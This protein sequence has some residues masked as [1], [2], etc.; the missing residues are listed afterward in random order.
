MKTCKVMMAWP[1][2]PV[3]CLSRCSL[4]VGPS[5]PSSGKPNRGCTSLRQLRKFNLSQELMVQFYTATIESVITMSITVW[6]S[7]ATKHDTHGV[8]HIIKSAVK[9][10]GVKLPTLLDQRKPSLIHHSLAIT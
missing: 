1:I 6:G 3:P 9:T 7:S 10:T 8:N 5:A 2:N 4:K